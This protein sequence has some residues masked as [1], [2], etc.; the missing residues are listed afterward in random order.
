MPFVSPKQQIY[1]KINHPEI[2][3]RWQKEY[4]NA[5]GLSKYLKKVRHNKKSQ[6]ISDMI[7]LAYYCDKNQMADLADK[8]EVKL[9]QINEIEASCNQCGNIIGIPAECASCG[10]KEAL[11]CPTCVMKKYGNNI[12]PDCGQTLNIKTTESNN[13][14]KI[15]IISRKLT[16]KEKQDSP[17]VFPKTHRKVKDN[18][19]H[20]PIPDLAHARNALAR[21]Q[22][23][24]GDWFDGTAE[25]L[26]AAVQRAVYKK[27]PGLKSR[28]EKRE[29]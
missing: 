6:Y 9:A 14:T 26:R 17:C 2:H 28:K 10:W 16:Y 24:I 29:E 25:E 12:C 15:K 8:I 22:Q 20:Y 4:G 23:D 1:L 11:L 7:Q 13:N 19:D 18:K 3:D 21:C 5:K 27:F